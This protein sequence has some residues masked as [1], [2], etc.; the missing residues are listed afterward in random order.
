MKAVLDKI[1]RRPLLK[2]V[3]PAGIKDQDEAD[4]K[5]EIVRSAKKFF[6]DLMSTKGRRTT[7]DS[8]AFWAAAAALLPAS[9]LKNRKSKEAMR[10]LG[11]NYR[12]V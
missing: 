9:L 12:V 11:V 3:L 10:L 1:L 4:A 6:T 5:D 2:L 8:N 7:I